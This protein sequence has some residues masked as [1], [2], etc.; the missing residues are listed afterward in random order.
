MS[1]P[2]QSIHVGLCGAG[3]GGLAAAIALCRAGATVTVLEAA[4]ELGEI[5]AGIQMTPNASRLLMKWG[6]ADLIGDNLVEFEELNMRKRDGTKVG[7][8]RMMPNIKKDLGYPWWVVHRAHLHAGLVEVAERHGAKILINSRVTSISYKS[9]QLVT[10]TTSTDSTYTFDLLIGSDGVNSV[11]RRT[12]FPDIRPTPPTSNCAYR[13]IVPYAQIREDLIARELIEKLTMEVWMSDRS[14]IITYPIS[15]GQDF[16]LVLSH[17]V[18][19]DRL[20]E[21]VEDVDI[22]EV[23]DEYADYDPR[24]KR[25]VDMIP[26]A[27][28]WPL[29][30]T[31]PLKSWTSNEK[32]IVLMGDAAH[33]MTNH[34]AQGA[35]TSMEDGAFLGRCIRSVIAGQITLSQAL[36]IYEKERMPKTH[37]KQQVSFLNG[38]IWQL[39]DG[40]AQ[41]ARDAAMQAELEGRPFSRSSNLYGDPQTVL[42]VYG[43]DAEAHADGAV[44]EYLKGRKRGDWR[45]GMGIEKEVLDGI[46]RWWLPEE[47]GREEA[48]EYGVQIESK[49]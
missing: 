4:A 25:I 21:S 46:V 33:S 10:V 37:F 28:R 43:Y 8:T 47:E 36:E 40:S 11:V 6:V 29:L 7:Y 1:H 23:R 17:H 16:N 24:I 34:M 49:L 2:K 20:V 22:K 31:G 12:L 48:N 27:Q 42:R 41:G 39:P 15:A 13:A 3:I 44:H 14:Y 32:N 30:V 5:G 38:A 18:P 26:S 19:N 35:A 45:K 9:S